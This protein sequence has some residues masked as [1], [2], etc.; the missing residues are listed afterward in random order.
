[1]PLNKVQCNFYFAHSPLVQRGLSGGYAR[2]RDWLLIDT[3]FIGHNKK[4]IDHAHHDISQAFGLL[5]EL[6]FEFYAAIVIAVA[7]SEYGD[8]AFRGNRKGQSASGKIG[9]DAVADFDP[10]EVRAA[11]V[12]P[13][14]L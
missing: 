12:D 2:L 8:S 14:R 13:Y 5:F 4:Q 3:P 1:M 9:Q 7:A 10:V 6:R 11:P